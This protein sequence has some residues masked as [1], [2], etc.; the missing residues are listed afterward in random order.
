MITKLVKN[1]T[2]TDCADLSN[3]VE[4]DTEC[5]KDQLQVTRK[6]VMLLSLWMRNWGEELEFSVLKYR[7]ILTL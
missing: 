5:R 6:E 4:K 1:I 2:V 3:E 7:E